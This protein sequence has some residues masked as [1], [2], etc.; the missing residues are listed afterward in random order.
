MPAADL[1]S[2][3]LVLGTQRVEGETEFQKFSS[4]HHMGTMAYANSV[5]STLANSPEPLGH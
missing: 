3:S 5:P 1:D 4:D 2:L